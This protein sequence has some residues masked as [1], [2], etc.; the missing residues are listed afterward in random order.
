MIFCYLCS[1][2]KKTSSHF[3]R[4]AVPNVGCKTYANTSLSPSNSRAAC[5][6]TRANFP[7]P[8]PALEEIAIPFQSFM[9]SHHARRARMASRDEQLVLVRWDGCGSFRLHRTNSVNVITDHYV[10][11]GSITA[12]YLA[13]STAFGCPSH[14]AASICPNKRVC[15]TSPRLRLTKA[16]GS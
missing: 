2:E 13:V 16:A 9:T 7:C 14:N 4:I 1:L 3:K 10:P 6:R 15:Q 8:L 12:S 5:S 11:N